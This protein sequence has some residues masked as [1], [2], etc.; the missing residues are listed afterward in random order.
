[1]EI[2][3]KEAAAALV[4]DGATVVI[5]GSGAGHAVPEAIMAAIEARFLADA[6][7]QAI[8][9]LHPVGL[10]ERNVLGANH[11]AHEGLLKRIVCGTLVDAPKVAALA[12]ADKIE[13]YTL[14]QG[15]LSQLMRDMAGGRPGLVTHVGLH[16]FVDPRHEGGRQSPRSKEDLVEVVELAGR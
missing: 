7:P 2:I 10:G 6:H 16:T 12:S 5:G 3:T 11:F 14:P 1:M 13:A 15:A 8:T 4:P 9:S